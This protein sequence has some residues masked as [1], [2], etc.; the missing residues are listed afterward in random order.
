MHTARLETSAK[1]E[2]VLHV[3]DVRIGTMITMAPTMTNLIVTIL[4]LGGGQ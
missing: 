1:R 4:W 2:T 3:N